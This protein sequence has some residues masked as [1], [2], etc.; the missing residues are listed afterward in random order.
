MPAVGVIRCAAL[1]VILRCAAGTVREV[2][3]GTSLHECMADGDA[4]KKSGAAAKKP[5]GLVFTSTQQAQRA[6]VC[7]R[8]MGVN[9]RQPMQELALSQ[10]T[11]STGVGFLGGSTH[12]IS[13][14][15][16]GLVLQVINYESSRKC[17][18]SH[19]DTPLQEGTN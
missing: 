1:A 3:Q 13:I 12:I 2:M 17:D 14:G 18:A 11:H 7:P 6:R 4:C 15:I 10:R 16:S 9:G 8:C 19:C 5:R